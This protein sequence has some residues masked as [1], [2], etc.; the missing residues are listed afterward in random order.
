MLR[1]RLEQAKGAVVSACML[2]GRL[3]Q[4]KGAVVSACML[5]GRLGR[6]CRQSG[7]L[8]HLGRFRVLQRHLLKRLRR[9]RLLLLLRR[10][11]L[12]LLRRRRLR[13]WLHSWLHS[14][15]RRRRHIQHQLR[16]ELI[17]DK[18]HRSRARGGLL[19]RILRWIMLL[20]R[21]PMLLWPQLLWL[22]LL[23][24]PLLRSILLLLL[25]L[26]PLRLR[27]GHRRRYRYQ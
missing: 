12:L 6:R 17:A 25:P 15:W 19:R 10:R 11:R 4:A 8:G 26:R 5:R 16:C 22:L 14:F 3:E 20:C 2:R 7:H 13:R 1:G 21:L 9:R 24:R 27:L 23:L 18:V